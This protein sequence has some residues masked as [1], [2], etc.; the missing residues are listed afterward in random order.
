MQ[1][2][3][4]CVCSMMAVRSS[5]DAMEGLIGELR[6]GGEVSIAAVNGSKSVMLSGSTNGVNRVMSDESIEGVRH[7][8]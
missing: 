5:R 2:S 7:R 4:S 3:V 6:L 8:M 1:D